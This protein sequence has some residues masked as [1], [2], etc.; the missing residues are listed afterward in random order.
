MPIALLPGRPG[1]PLTAVA[2]G[3]VTL[4]DLMNFVASARA[5]DQWMRALLVDLSGDTLLDIPAADVKRFADDLGDDTKRSG[6]RGL[7]A[8]VAPSDQVFGVAR[9]LITY[10]QIAG[11]EHIAVFRTKSAAE[12]WL[13]GHTP[14]A[15]SG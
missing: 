7:V 11:A 12:A 9:M 2:T 6:P 3:N 5:G 13:A 8:M 14:S 10:G 15:E 1:G 4:G